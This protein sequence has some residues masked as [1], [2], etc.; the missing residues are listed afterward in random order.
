MRTQTSPGF[1]GAQ[2]GLRGSIQLRRWRQRHRYSRLQPPPML[3]LTN[4]TLA[5]GAKRLLDGASLTVHPG[6]KVGLIGPNGC[7]KSSLFALIRGELLPDAGDVQLPAAWTVA[8]VAQE[9]PSAAVP[10]IDFVQDGDRELREV[11]RAM[12]AAEARPRRRPARG[13]RGAGR[14]APPLRGDR[15]LRGAR[16]R[17]HAAR[18]ASAFPTRA[19]PTRWRASPAAGGCGSTSRR[20]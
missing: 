11:E 1:A 7:G 12:A 10:A 13:R 14:A 8:H 17:R 15:R 18:P 6:H 20:R 3:R 5:R 9:T 2:P 4:L 16:A 19:T